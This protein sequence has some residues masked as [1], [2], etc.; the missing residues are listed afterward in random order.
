MYER[1][2]ELSSVRAGIRGRAAMA[3][4]ISKG[5]PEEKMLS[6]EEKSEFKKACL[7][8]NKEMSKVMAEVIET[9]DF[10]NDAAELIA[11]KIIA[12]QSQ[13]ATFRL[14]LCGGST[15]EGPA[16]GLFGSERHRGADSGQGERVADWDYLG[17][18]LFK[19]VTCRQTSLQL[20]NLDSTTSTSDYRLYE[21]RGIPSEESISNKHLR[22]HRLH[23]FVFVVR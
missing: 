2:H 3:G 6:G 11:A 13:G 15:P 8:I 7:T 23:E 16:V 18:A 10:V 20:L 12:K 9:S 21:H 14:S 19:F 5:G 1:D 22:L 4:G 17:P